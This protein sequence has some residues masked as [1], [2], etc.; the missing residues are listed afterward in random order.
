MNDQ[1]RDPKNVRK[2][3]VDLAI[4]ERRGITNV[5][6]LSSLIRVQLGEEIEAVQSNNNKPSFKNMRLS[7]LLG[8]DRIAVSRVHLRQ[9]IMIIIIKIIN[10]SIFTIIDTAQSP[11]P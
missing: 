10:Q 2:D 1:D 8:R 3:L 4:V 5:V 11:L 7:P 9:I 6:E